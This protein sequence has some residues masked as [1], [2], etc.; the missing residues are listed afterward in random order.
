MTGS[1][2]DTI[3]SSPLATSSP[4]VHGREAQQ[5]R[6]AAAAGAPPAS[7]D[8]PAGWRRAGMLLHVTSLPGPDGIGDLG[9][10]SREFVTWLAR[11]G[12]RVWQTLPLHP[13]SNAAMSPYDASSAVSYTHLTL[14]TSDLV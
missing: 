7:D 14:P 5:A 9:A 6:A 12:Q 11:A 8:A 1:G 13:P 4:L 10:P 2:G 3:A